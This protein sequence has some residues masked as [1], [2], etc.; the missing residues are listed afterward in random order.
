MWRWPRPVQSTSAPRLAA[1]AP[2]SMSRQLEIFCRRRRPALFRPYWA[3]FQSAAIRLRW[4]VPDHFPTRVRS[5]CHLDIK[6]TPARVAIRPGFFRA[7]H[8]GSRRVHS[9]AASSGHDHFVIS[10]HSLSG[11][12][13]DVLASYRNNFRIQAGRAEQFPDRGETI[14][15]SSSASQFKIRST[16][17]LVRNPKHKLPAC[18]VRL[19]LS[20]RCDR[21]A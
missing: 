17:W 13:T 12:G 14:D 15:L 2:P 18:V 20:L 19:G 16:F 4:L 21:F 3:R 10:G 9:S 11:G 7:C 8:L 5:V 6:K 1:C